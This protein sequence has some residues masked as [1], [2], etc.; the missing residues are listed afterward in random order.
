MDTLDSDE[1]CIHSSHTFIK[2]GFPW[3]MLDVSIDQIQSEK[4]TQSK[5]QT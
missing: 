4:A 5:P 3:S 2:D 1:N